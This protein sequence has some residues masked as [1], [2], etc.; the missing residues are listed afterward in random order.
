MATSAVIHRGT[1]RIRLILRNISLL[2]SLLI[3][4]CSFHAITSVVGQYVATVAS[5]T[6]GKLL[7]NW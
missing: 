5:V 1:V 2:E 7:V 3:V 4:Y 6:V